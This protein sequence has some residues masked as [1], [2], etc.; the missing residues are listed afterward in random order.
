MADQIIKEPRSFRQVKGGLF[1]AI[2]Y[3][4]PARPVKF[5]RTI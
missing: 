2:S 5:L 4:H 1:F 3:V